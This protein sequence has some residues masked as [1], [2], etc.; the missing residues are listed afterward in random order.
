MPGKVPNPAMQWLISHHADDGSLLTLGVQESP[1]GPRLMFQHEGHGEP[2]LL[3]DGPLQVRYVTIGG[4]RRMVAFGDDND[5]PQAEQVR[6]NT[7]YQVGGGGPLLKTGGYHRRLWMNGPEPWFPQDE[8]KPGPVTAQWVGANPN[9]ILHEE[10]TPWL[11]W[12]TPWPPA[13]APRLKSNNA[14]SGMERLLVQEV[15]DGSHLILGLEYVYE[16]HSF[17]EELQLS[18]ERDGGEVPE[19]SGGWHLQLMFQHE[20]HGEP[21]QLP[22]RGVC[23]CGT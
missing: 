10:I 8:F 3:P 16:E 2:E 18:V 22:L 1:E 11:E 17:L 5:E 4:R 13:D 23:V 19:V 15:E 14:R 21:D 9:H 12:G 20:G 6:V 7:G